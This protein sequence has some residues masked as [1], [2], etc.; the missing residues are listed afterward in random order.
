MPAMTIRKYRPAAGSDDAES[1]ALAEPVAI[2]RN[3]II[4]IR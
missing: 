1:E 3:R 2:V 4:N